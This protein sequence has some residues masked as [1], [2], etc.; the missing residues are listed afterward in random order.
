MIAGLGWAMVIS[1]ALTSRTTITMVA[2]IKTTG[3]MAM[4]APTRTSSS[5]GIM[6][7]GE[8]TTRKTRN[9]T[10]TTP[11]KP[12]TTATTGATQLVVE[13]LLLEEARHERITIW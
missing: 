13:H 7:I 3:E 10:T 4:V 2:I 1:K 6:I 5:M 11:T 12:T 9:P 8:R